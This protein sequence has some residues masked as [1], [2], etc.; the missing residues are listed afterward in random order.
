LFA[1][2]DALLKL[3]YLTLANIVKKCSTPLRDWSAVMARFTIQFEEWMPTTSHP[4]RLHKIWDILH[5][6][7]TNPW[8]RL[9]YLRKVGNRQRQH[10]LRLEI[11]RNLRRL[12][13]LRTLPVLFYLP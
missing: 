1:S 10:Q 11:R 3:F 4:L 12:I 8:R 6:R 13:P 5:T 9:A 2:D 7:S